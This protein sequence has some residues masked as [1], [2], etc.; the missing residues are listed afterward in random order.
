[1]V[2]PN[3]GPK[4]ERSGH[5]CPSDSV[6]VAVG[7]KLRRLIIIVRLTALTLCWL[8]CLASRANLFGANLIRLALLN[9]LSP[10]IIMY[11]V[12]TPTFKVSALAV[13]MIPISFLL[14]SCLITRWKSV[15]TL[16]RR[17]VNFLLKVK[18]NR[19]KRKVPK[20]LRSSRFLITLLMTWWT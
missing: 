3:A 18:W 17:G 2:T 11:C 12:G 14:N 4:S 16:V 20:L 15:I 5:M 8:V 9:P 7:T 6:V 1:M 19:E 13:K 10:L